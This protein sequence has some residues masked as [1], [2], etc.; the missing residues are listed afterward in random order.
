MKATTNYQFLRCRTCRAT[1]TAA[2]EAR[3]HQDS[4]GH[5][6]E[7]VSVWGSISEAAKC[8]GACLTATGPD[9]EC[10]CGGQHHGRYAVA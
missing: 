6:V 5:Q 7:F 1:W 9:C 3:A 4:T 10:Q 8:G 2:T